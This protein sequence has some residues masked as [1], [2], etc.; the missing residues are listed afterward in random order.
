[1]ADIIWSSIYVVKLGNEMS[2]M[3][4]PRSPTSYAS[5]TSEENE[6]VTFQSAHVSELAANYGVKMN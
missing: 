1:M 3:A 4:R 5:K 2:C 6:P